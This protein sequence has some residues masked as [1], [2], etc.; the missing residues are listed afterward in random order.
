MIF[1]FFAMLC[2]P[3]FEMRHCMHHAICTYSRFRNRPHRNSVRILLDAY[4]AKH[5]AMLRTI[6]EFIFRLTVAKFLIYIEEKSFQTNKGNKMKWS[7]LTHHNHFSWIIQWRKRAFGD[8]HL[9]V[10]SSN[11]FIFF[12]I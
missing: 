11:F 6:N 5:Y 7:Y 9:M 1:N 10:L 4:C 8:R 12:F 3:A 2:S